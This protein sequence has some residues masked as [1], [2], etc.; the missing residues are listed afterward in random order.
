MDRTTAFEYIKNKTIVSFDDVEYYPTAYILRLNDGK[1]CHSLELH[2]LNADSVT[3][4][5]M[6]KVVI[7]QCQE[8]K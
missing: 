5:D 3:I 4:A 6:G 7:K 8:Q 2:D 1:W